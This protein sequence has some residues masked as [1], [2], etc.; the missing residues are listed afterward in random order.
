[1]DV[2]AFAFW[3]GDPQGDSILR[4]YDRSNVLIGTVTAG[5]NTGS[6]PNFSDSFAGFISTEPVG[7][8]EFEGLTGDGWNHYDDFHVSFGA[9]PEPST[10][11][12]VLAGLGMLGRVGRRNL[13][14]RPRLT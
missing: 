11:V 14:T 8:L 12:L 3:Y 13:G 6:A 1:M 5:I 7:R 2:R 9:V 4:I 10:L